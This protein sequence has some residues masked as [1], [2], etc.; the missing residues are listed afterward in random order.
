MIFRLNLESGVPVYRQIIDQVHAG[1]ASG[2]LAPGQ[3]L[4]TVRQL[5]VDLK[6]NPNTVVRAYRELELTG[7]L[8][9]HQ[10]TGTFITEA[11]IER[12]EAEHE[13]K[14]DRLVAEFAARAGREGFTIRELR[15]RLKD[16]AESGAKTK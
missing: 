1:R 8:T 7:F 13:E 12:S 3:R 6:V 2:S 9:T 11:K 15:A 5:A 4:P 16:F 14:L 10:G